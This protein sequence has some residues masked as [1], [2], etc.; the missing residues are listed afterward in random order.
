MSLRTSDGTTALL[1]ME[2]V[3]CITSRPKANGNN[4]SPSMCSIICQ[5]ISIRARIDV[6][7]M[8]RRPPFTRSTNGPRSGVTTANGAMVNSR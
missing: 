6:M 5:A 2:Y 7:I 1:A 3:F 8:P 4:N